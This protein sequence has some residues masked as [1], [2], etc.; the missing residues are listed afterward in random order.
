[1]RLASEQNVPEKPSVPAPPRRLAPQA[2]EV[3][4]PQRNVSPE[5]LPPNGMI[6]FRAVS[7]AG[8]MYMAWMSG[9]MCVGG[10]FVILYTKLHEANAELPWFVPMAYRMSIIVLVGMASWSILR[11]SR[12]LSSI[13][14]LP[15]KDQAR[16]LFKIRRNIPLPLIKPKVLIVPA[17]D[18]SLERRVVASMGSPVLNAGSMGSLDGNIVIRIARHVAGAFSR[19]F[20]GARQFFFDDG[21]IYVHVKGHSGKWKLDSNG[22]LPDGDQ[23][24]LKIVRI[25]DMEGRFAKWT[26]KDS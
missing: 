1:M 4:A 13:E 15:G 16:L 18:V 12:L 5:V 21:I 8:H 6:A 7:Q 3:L 10:V 19:F 22:L 14:I 9:M 2:F 26:A 25:E 20:V 23:L 24:F 11:S 17:S